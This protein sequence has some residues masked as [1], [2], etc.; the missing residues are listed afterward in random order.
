MLRSFLMWFGAAWRGQVWPGLAWRGSVW[1]SVA[2]LLALAMPAGAGVTSVNELNSAAVVGP[3][4]ETGSHKTYLTASAPGGFSFSTGVP[5]VI[6]HWT[7]WSEDCAHLADFEVCLTLNDSVVID[8][9]DMG[10]IGIG[11]ERLASRFDLSGYRGTYTV[12]SFETDQRCRDPADTGFRLA[13]ESINSSWTIANQATNSAFGDRAFALEVD[14]TTGDIDVPDETFDAV[15]LAFFQPDT[16]TDS[17]VVLITVVENFGDF[18]HEIGPPQGRIVLGAR[19]RACDTQEACLSLPDVQFSCALFG[20]LIPGRG[21]LIPETL[22]PSSSGF[23]RLSQGRFVSNDVGITTDNIFVYAFHGQALKQFGTGARGVYADLIDVVPTPT[24][25]SSPT[26][27]ASPSPT[28]ATATPAV[29]PT[30]G[31]SPTGSPSP[32][33]G[34]SPTPTAGVASPTPEATATP[35]STPTPV[36]TQVGITPSPTPTPFLFSPSPFPSASPTPA[37]TPT[38]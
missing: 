29:T 1:Q 31:P 9:A 14:P 20:S 38:P 17:E 30:P 5:A 21:N 8:V 32:T 27:I 24:P 26:P 22:M 12:H 35:A 25:S 33:P 6:T 10:G 2:L 13:A 11:N 23:Y 37:P 3:F 7:F 15:D 36:A 4:D 19:A 28:L 18:P 34:Q 16:L